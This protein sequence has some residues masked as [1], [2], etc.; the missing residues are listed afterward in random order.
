MP[1]RF[2]KKNDDSKEK[3]YKELAELGADAEAFRKVDPPE[4]QLATL[5]SALRRI[6]ICTD[7]QKELLR[8]RK[9]ETFKARKHNQSVAD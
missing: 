8:R 5:V 1:K 4:E 3:L 2:E 6:K 7:L 9:S